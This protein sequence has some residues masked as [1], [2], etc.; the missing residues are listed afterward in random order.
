MINEIISNSLKYAFTNDENTN[1]I[2][3]KMSK[4]K[5]N[6]YTMVIGD[7]GK[8]SEIGL[9]DEHGTFGME[10]IK[11]LT[12]QLHGTIKQLSNKGTLYEITFTPVK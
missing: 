8:G 3:F 9:N 1:V 12:E 5:D 4:N 7:N 10:L 6:S 11:T 2:I